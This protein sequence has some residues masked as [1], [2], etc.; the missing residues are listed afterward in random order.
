LDRKETL[1]IQI[2]SS[3]TEDDEFLYV[4][5]IAIKA[6]KVQRFY[7]TLILS[8]EELQRAAPTFVGKP[9]VKDHEYSV[10]SVVG[11]VLSSEYKDGAIFVKARI[12]KNGNEKLVSLI[13][14]GVVKKLSAGFERELTKVGDREYLAK[15]IKFQELSIVLDPAIPDATILS[16][17][18]KEDTMSQEKFEALARE[19]EK[20]KSQLSQLQKERDELKKQVEVLQKEIENLKQ[21]A[22]LGKTYRETLE[23]DAEKFIKVVDGEDSPLLGL[24]TKADITQLQKLVET[25]REKAQEKLKPSAKTGLKEEGKDVNVDKLSYSE[26]KALEEKLMGGQ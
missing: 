25:Y 24:I 1:S 2:P 12:L 4:D 6:A 5:A 20:L 26:L 16:N 17:Q 11:D 10:D 18:Q 3:I 8:E 9:V 23:K 15:N 7:G 22:E 21:L 14:K 13:K 19:N